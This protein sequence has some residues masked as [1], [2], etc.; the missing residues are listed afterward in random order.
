[1]CYN[2][3]KC[4]LKEGQI[5]TFNDFH[6]RSDVLGLQVTAWVLLPDA[7]VMAQQGGKPLPTLY[8]LHGLSD[9]HTMW[10]RNTRI[11]QYANQYRMAVVMPAVARSF[12]TDMASGAGK[13]FTFVSE[14]LPRVMETYFPLS[15][16]REDRFA[17]GLSM[18]GYGAMKLGLR[19]PDRYGAI[20][21]L[22]GA[23]EMERDYHRPR[24]GGEN[25]FWHELNGIFGSE[26]QLLAGNNNLSLVADKLAA[27]DAP[28]IYV[29]CG[30][31]D[32]LFDYNQHFVKTFGEKFSIH[33][34]V[35]PG[36]A[37]T[38]DYWDSQIQ[39]VLQWLE[40]PKAERGW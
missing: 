21:S 14:E 36:A 33:Y 11:E 10:M 13:Y 29:A 5:M 18:G 27:K 19:L 8:L 23:V 15:K 4:F 1:M 25:E 39:K 20:A 6:F 34:E 26:E 30:D 22:S 37:H 24:G 2:T 9:D 12:Y 28:R 7:N 38:W 35:T 32:F 17:A 31:K 3:E 40:V 16:N